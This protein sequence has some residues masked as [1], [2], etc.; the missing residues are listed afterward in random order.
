[1]I[2][3]EE[4]LLL[5]LL[6]PEVLSLILGLLDIA[7]I[8]AFRACSQACHEIV[9]T[10]SQ[11]IYESVAYLQYGMDVPCTAGD[12]GIERKT[13][14]YATQDDMTSLKR[15]KAR[16]RTASHVYDDADTWQE[17][18]KRRS[19]VDRTWKKGQPVRR[20]LSLGMGPETHL[21]IWRK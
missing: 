20:H 19:K 6:P 8:A 13:I 11:A 9:E 14:D 4:S 15:A 18:V 5:R 17:L 16:Q 21:C 10:G 2:D 1:M 7:S 3:T 12:S